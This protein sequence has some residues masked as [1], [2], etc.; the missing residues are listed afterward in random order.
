MKE[1]NKNT[2]SQHSKNTHLNTQH[3][4][5]YKKQFDG[6]RKLESLDFTDV[7]SPF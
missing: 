4:Q 1:P 2:G 3:T 5:T 7:F 6:Q